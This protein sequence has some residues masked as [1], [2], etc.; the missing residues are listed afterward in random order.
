MSSR[1]GVC[2]AIQGREHRRRDVLVSCG[3]PIKRIFGMIFVSIIVGKNSPKA[4]F[5]DQDPDRDRDKD[6]ITVTHNR[7]HPQSLTPQTRL[8]TMP[9]N[10]PRTS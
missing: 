7:Q 2:A 4:A 5:R 1:R 9:F 3:T 6:S 8:Y 10:H